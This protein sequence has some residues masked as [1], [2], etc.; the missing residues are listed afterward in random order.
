MHDWFL[1]Q[2]QGQ[3]CAVC[4]QVCFKVVVCVEIVGFQMSVGRV[5]ACRVCRA[6]ATEFV[7]SF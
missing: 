1:K 2:F 4:C 6:E 3:M 5:E 7:M